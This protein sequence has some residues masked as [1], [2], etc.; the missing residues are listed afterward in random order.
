MNS[1]S[2]GNQI[3][4]GV[5]LDLETD[6]DSTEPAI[7]S[8]VTVPDNT[9]SSNVN[10]TTN[11]PATLTGIVFFTQ[12]FFA[13]FLLVFFI[14][15]EIDSEK[16]K[17]VKLI[18]QETYDKIIIYKLNPTDIALIERKKIKAIAQTFDSEGEAGSPWPKGQLLY[19]VQFKG[20]LRIG[21][22][23]LCKLTPHNS[24]TLIKLNNII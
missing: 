1:L 19:K 7:D 15:I 18:D 2:I 24:T 8:T 5:A 23:I 20:N 21:I 22:C 3:D 10:N 17:R 16:K 11:N 6:I 4:H 14:L 12:T 13:S 9:N